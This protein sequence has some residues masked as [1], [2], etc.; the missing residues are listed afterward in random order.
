V[1]REKEAS[2]HPEQQK[3]GN[4]PPSIHDRVGN[5]YDAHDVLNACK[6]H[7]EDGASCGY[8][9]RRGGR[10]DS[11]EGRSLL[12]PARFWQPA[13]IT[14]YAEETNPELWLDDY[15]LAC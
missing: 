15:C 7:K 12:F 13:N 14:K 10:Y 9:P 4:K 2:V 1:P 11:G 8:H 3:A 5:N 6:R